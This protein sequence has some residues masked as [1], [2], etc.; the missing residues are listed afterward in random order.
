MPAALV[1]AR[2][3]GHGRLA[4]LRDLHDLQLLLRL[5]HQLLLVSLVNRNTGSTVA[6][7]P[8]QAMTAGLPNTT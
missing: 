3:R 8:Q 5:L 1:E 2:R 6:P 7:T 4:P